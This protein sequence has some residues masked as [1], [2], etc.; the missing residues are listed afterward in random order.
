MLM[1]F[2]AVWSGTADPFWPHAVLLSLSVLAGIA[3]GAGIIFEAPKYSSATHRVAILLVIFGVAIES[4][5]TICLFVFDER[6][7][8]VQSD[9]IESLTK[10]LRIA[11]IHAADRLI[12]DDEQ[13]KFVL[14][15][16]IHL[17]DQELHIFTLDNDQE[18]RRFAN[19]LRNLMVPPLANW[20]VI[21]HTFNEPGPLAG[22]VVGPVPNG[23]FGP[24]ANDPNDKK[25]DEAATEL[26][27]ALLLLDFCVYH[28]DFTRELIA[29]PQS[30]ITLL[31]SGK[32]RSSREGC[33]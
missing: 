26:Y 30:G 2:S 3:V 9:R 15:G 11:E 29:K 7:S 20:E 10:Q 28:V 22:S 25:A 6:I 32:D 17:R 8:Q 31:I 19:S 21:F 27:S 12:T 5:C 23:I 33:K 4:V 1:Y 24:F 16:G 18:A 13:E 14:F